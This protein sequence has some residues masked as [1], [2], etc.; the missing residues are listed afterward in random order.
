MACAMLK[1]LPDYA[2]LPIVRTRDQAVIDKAAIAVDVGG[3]YEP[4]KHR[5]D[6]H[7]RSFTDTYSKDYPEIKLSSAGLVFKHF[8]ADVVKALCGPIDEKAVA[9]I[10]AKAYDS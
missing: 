7:Q 8:G 4:S 1:C 6:H 10:V 2:T 9:V 3:S 5:Y